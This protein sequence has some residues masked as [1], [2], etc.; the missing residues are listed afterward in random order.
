MTSA[1]KIQVI[2]AVQHTLVLPARRS[3]AESSNQTY[4]R[5]IDDQPVIQIRNSPAGCENHTANPFH[6]LEV[7]LFNNVGRFMVVPDAPP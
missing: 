7:D 5:F 2:R 1:M 3:A 4:C 6:L